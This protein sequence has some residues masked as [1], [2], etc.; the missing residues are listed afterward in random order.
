MTVSE[1]REE[2]FQASELPAIEYRDATDE[3]SDEGTLETWGHVMTVLIRINAV[4]MAQVRTIL[5]TIQN[6]ISTEFQAGGYFANHGMLV[7][8][9]TDESD[10]AHK[11]KKYFSCTFP[12]YINYTTTEWDP[13]NS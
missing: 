1:W 8:R 9:G 2:P 13:Y 3:I 11:E 4:T 6:A 12:L 10:V 5:G 7:R